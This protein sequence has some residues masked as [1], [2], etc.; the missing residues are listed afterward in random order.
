MYHYGLA[1]A[2]FDESVERLADFLFHPL[3][4]TNSEMRAVHA[5]HEKN[6]QTPGWRYDAVGR[7]VFDEKGVGRFS[8][9]NLATLNKPELP[10]QLKRFNKKFYQPEEMV[11][12]TVGPKTVEEQ[13]AVVEKF[14][15]RAG[16]AAPSAAKEE[17]DDRGG[18]LAGDSGPQS[19]G[20]ESAEGASGPPVAAF[21]EDDSISREAEAG[22][23][24]DLQ[25]F[26]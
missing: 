12:V 3:L 4:K 5:E 14:W 9:G 15:T 22:A 19:R 23:L 13:L 25:R 20:G 21:L 24:V 6:I 8:T 17:A 18:A 1:D 26:G 16:I 10:E 2:G 11:L 7:F